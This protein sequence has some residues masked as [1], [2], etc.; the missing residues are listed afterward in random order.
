MFDALKA[1][2]WRNRFIMPALKQAALRNGHVAESPD[3]MIL[4]ELW[5]WA[6]FFRFSG[7]YRALPPHKQAKLRGEAFQLSFF[8]YRNLHKDRLAAMMKE[9]EPKLRPTDTSAVL[10]G[11]YQLI[12]PTFEHSVVEAQALPPLHESFDLTTFRRVLSKVHPSFLEMPGMEAG[13]HE[14]G[15]QR[16]LKLITQAAAVGQAQ[17]YAALTGLLIPAD[18]VLVKEEQIPDLADVFISYARPDA[19]FVSGLAQ[20]LERAGLAVWYDRRIQP[21]QQFDQA[22]SEQIAASKV[23]LTVWSGASV[24]SKWVRAESLAGFNVNKLLQVRIGAC[25]IPTPFNIVQTVTVDPSDLTSE[26]L[27]MLLEAVRRMIGATPITKD[28][29]SSRTDNTT[30]DDAK[31][32]YYDHNTWREAFIVPA[33]EEAEPVLYLKDPQVGVAAPLL[34]EA[35]FWGFALNLL[36]FKVPSDE[37]ERIVPMLRVTAPTQFWDAAKERGATIAGSVSMEFILT[38]HRLIA[39]STE[40]VESELR[41]H[42]QFQTPVPQLFTQFLE[43]SEATIPSQE[44]HAA[45]P[46]SSSDGDFLLGVAALAGSTKLFEAFNKTVLNA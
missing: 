44:R 37:M 45:F 35:F 19:E 23:V 3:V 28:V 27:A 13:E 34:L 21:E 5:L 1:V 6:V 17:L 26:G 18:T 16:N 43:M 42:G 15:R 2:G 20:Y 40:V 12:G 36:Q 46:E 14:R 32:W 22:I 11:F 7:E 24:G 9:H 10:V 39:A 31:P 4:V 33:L 29:S 8:D 38:F 30:S 41:E 25:E